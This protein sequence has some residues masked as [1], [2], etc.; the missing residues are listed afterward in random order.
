MEIVPKMVRCFIL[1]VCATWAFEEGAMAALVDWTHAPCT[2]YHEDVGHLFRAS[3]IS[4][5]YSGRAVTF[6]L[7]YTFQADAGTDVIYDDQGL[8]ETL[9]YMPS[10]TIDTLGF[11]G[12]WTEDG[13]SHMLAVHAETSV[14]G[15]TLK[16]FD[17]SSQLLTEILNP[18]DVNPVLLGTNFS[19]PGEA[20]TPANLL[21]KAPL[22]KVFHCEHV[23]FNLVQWTND[24]DYDTDYTDDWHVGDEFVGKFE[25]RDF[26]L[27]LNINSPGRQNIDPSSLYNPC[28]TESALKTCH[29]VD[30]QLSCLDPPD[31]PAASSTGGLDWVLDPLT[32]AVAPTYDTNVSTECSG[33]AHLFRASD[34]TY[35]YS[36]PDVTFPLTYSFQADSR[37]DVEGNGYSHNDTDGNLRSAA[38]IH[39]N[40]TANGET[41]RLN[42]HAHT[43]VN[44]DAVLVRL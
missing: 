15:W 4:Y 18:E 28:R 5:T 3:D 37:V 30:D 32:V 24:V 19:T 33:G 38:V 27:A 44:L 34:M 41:Q 1:L 23:E 29:I 20:V 17:I 36:G 11:S 40:W 10:D 42:V 26:M 25:A 9:Y 2:A 39:G 13:K 21:V 7:T 35:T 12:N 6:P 16:W 22:G 8:Y 14:N 43:T 31:A